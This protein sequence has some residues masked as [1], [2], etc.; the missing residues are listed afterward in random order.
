MPQQP[1]VL[2]GA[3]LVADLSGAL[4]WPERSLL[5]VADLH[6]EKASSFARRGRFLPPYDTAQTLDRL[7]A[8]IS[9]VAP[10]TVI[11]L[12]DS[13]HDRAAAERVSAA[14]AARIRTLT[15]GRDWIW[16]VGNHDPEPPTGWGG[17]TVPETAIGPLLFRHEARPQAA[18]EVSGHFHPVAAVRVRG[19]RL[20]VRC[21]AHD[22]RRL[23][24]PAFGAYAGGLNVLDPAL[25][26]VLGRPFTV[27]AL[28]R[29]RIF[30]LPSARLEADSVSGS[31]SDPASGKPDASAPRFPVVDPDA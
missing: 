31:A 12:G 16:V 27:H 29:E 22:G 8:L 18:G 3:R 1:I 9:R 4:L 21:F 7:G 2:D 28:G 6:L 5:A 19:Q 13:F 20:R 23:V 11:C 26:H 25:R 14:D 24:L 17:R 10:E 30:A 15:A